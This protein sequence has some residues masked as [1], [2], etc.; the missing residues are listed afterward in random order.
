MGHVLDHIPKAAVLGH[1]AAEED[2]LLADV[3]HGALGHLREH[4]E[5]RLL[6][7]V[8]DVLQGH[9][10][11]LQRERGVYHAGERDV[12]PLDGIGQLVVL[13]SAPCEPL[14]LRTGVEPHAEVPAELVQHVPDADVLRLPE[15][16]VAALGEG[17][18]LR[19]AAG[20][21][22]QGGVPA[23]REG[24]PDLYVGDAVVH[25]DYRDAH[26][27]REGPRG[28]GGHPEAGS[29]PGAHGERYEV[30]V[31]GTDAGLVQRLL[32]LHSCDLGVMVGGLAGMEA[33][34]GRTEHV[35]LVGQH[36][37]LRID[38]PDPE[39]VGRPLNPHREHWNRA[40]IPPYNNI[41]YA[42]LLSCNTTH[43]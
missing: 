33:P 30:D 27:A 2:L 15:D 42:G 35:E 40:L 32:H 9:P 36:V 25:S 24:A 10:P 43:P 12:H 31:I 34:L 29:E 39:R 20:C 14:Y 37:A 3:R 11:P 8:A 13:R 17:Y 38:D 21:I 5:G 23:A 6:D 1:P 41:N 4:G 7:G 22:E 19:V 18:D 28:G 16:P 26:H